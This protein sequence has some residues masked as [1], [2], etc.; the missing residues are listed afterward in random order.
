MI[1][2]NRLITIL[3]IE[4]PSTKAECI[5]VLRINVCASANTLIVRYTKRQ[6]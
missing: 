2:F 3:P 6:K 1:I 4:Q 5:N